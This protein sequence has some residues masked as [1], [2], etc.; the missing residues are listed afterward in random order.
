MGILLKT[1]YRLP[2]PARC[3]AATVQG[4]R[5]RHRRYGP[6]TETLVQEAHERESWSP[7]QWQAWTEERLA[8]VL[9]RAATRVP[10]YRDHWAERRRRGDRASW[11][12]LE[13]WPLLEKEEVRRA[14]ERFLSDDIPAGQLLR[15]MTS[16]TT[17]TPL[18]ISR[19]IETTRTLYALSLAR[20]RLWHGLSLRARWGMVGTRPVAP[21]WSRRPPFW[22]WNAA[23]GQLYM[24]CHQLARDLVQQYLDA[25]ARYR[26]VYL[27]GLTSSL[28][29][30]AQEI[31]ALGRRD[32]RMHVVSTN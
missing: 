19:T 30:L 17:G 15:E 13:N 20:T 27:Y 21:V 24:S 25:I 4:Y 16:G 12:R 3:V 28:V 7:A 14:P 29:A 18:V 8:Y 23:L 9:H 10:Y 2:Y 22:V 11:E 1:F 5:L 32:V 26:V 6:E 31:L